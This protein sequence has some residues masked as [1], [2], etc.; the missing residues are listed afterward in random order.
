MA[1]PFNGRAIRSLR[2]LIT[3]TRICGTQEDAHCW[4]LQE[5]AAARGE[6]PELLDPVADL[7]VNA[8]ELVGDIREQQRLLAQRAAMPAHW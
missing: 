8:F 6:E 2:H 7:R 5:D 1:G 4:L 3:A